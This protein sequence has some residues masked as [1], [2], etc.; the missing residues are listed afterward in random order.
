MLLLTRYFGECS[1]TFQNKKKHIW[2]KEVNKIFK[3][4]SIY[5]QFSNIIRN[6]NYFTSYIICIFT[7]KETSIIV[8]VY[9]ADHFYRRMTDTEM[10]DM[11]SQYEVKKMLYRLFYTYIIFRIFNYRG[12]FTCQR[13]LAKYF[14]KIYISPISF[15]LISRCF[16]L[17]DILLKIILKNIFLD[18]KGWLIPRDSFILGQMFKKYFFTHY[19]PFLV[20][21]SSING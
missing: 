3:H 4:L 15:R 6:L 16:L 12:T 18:M 20:I 7:F 14:E 21:F 17:V 5:S 10:E 2:K 11:D 13:S 1:M 19:L 8:F 9:L